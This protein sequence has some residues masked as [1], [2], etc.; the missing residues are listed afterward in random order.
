MSIFYWNVFSVVSKQKVNEMTKMLKEIH[1]QEDKTV[2][3]EKVKRV[4]GFYAIYVLPQFVAL[5][6]GVQICTHK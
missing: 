3:R 5:V 4:A 2:A 6:I 1:A